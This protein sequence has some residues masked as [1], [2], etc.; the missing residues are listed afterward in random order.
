[1]T[2][3]PGFDLNFLRRVYIS[4]AVAAL[5]MGLML[6]VYKPVDAFCFLAG[7][8]FGIANL[9]ALGKV[10]LALIKVGEIDLREA[11]LTIIIKFPIILVLFFV[12]LKKFV[13]AQGRVELVYWY[14]AGF[15]L[16]YA[17]ILLKVLAIII[18]NP[19]QGPPKGSAVA[20]RSG[21]GGDSI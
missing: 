11:V 19:K 20:K 18:F 21:D 10:I 4:T 5:L 6:V 14:V 7:A 9:W 3:Y 15:S 17:V 13:L 8:A 16:T 1:M 2:S 12:V